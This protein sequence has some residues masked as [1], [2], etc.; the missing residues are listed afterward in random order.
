MQMILT[1][2]ILR[3]GGQAPA[4][5]RVDL[6]TC[7]LVNLPV[8]FVTALVLHADP[9]FI[10]LSLRIDYLLKTLWGLWRIRRGNWIIR[11]NVDD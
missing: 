8:G 5:T 11:M 6:L 3:G 1:K 4:V 2:G 9:F 7:W 10:Y